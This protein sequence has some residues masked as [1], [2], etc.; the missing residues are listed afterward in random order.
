MTV[1][2]LLFLYLVER[3]ESFLHEIDGL[4]DGQVHSVRL[5][6][7]SDDASKDGGGHQPKPE[8]EKLWYR[9]KHKQ[10]IIIK[11]CP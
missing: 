3:G 10:L 11:L 2:A 6:P 9:T 7:G 1:E 5:Q 8:R 4:P